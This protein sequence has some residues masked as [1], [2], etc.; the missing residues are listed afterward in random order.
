MAHDPWLD[1]VNKFLTPPSLTNVTIVTD[2][3]S[4]KL[5]AVWGSLGNESLAPK[6][7]RFAD[8][9]LAIDR[10]SGQNRETKS[11]SGNSWVALDPPSGIGNRSIF[12][13]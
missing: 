7:K 5:V 2:G 1:V 13:A 12:M 6:L 3:P 10:L 9:C 4:P 11:G 8:H